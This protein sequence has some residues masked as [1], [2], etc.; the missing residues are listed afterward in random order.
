MSI[1]KDAVKE[2]KSV[3]IAINLQIARAF[4]EVRQLNPHTE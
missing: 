1:N 3:T 4:I 2:V